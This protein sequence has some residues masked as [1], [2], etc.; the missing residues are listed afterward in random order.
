[1]LKVAI[2]INSDGLKLG[3]GIGSRAEF[4]DPGVGSDV[5]HGEKVPAADGE[6]FPVSSTFGRDRLEFDEGVGRGAELVDRGVDIAA[7]AVA[8][9]CHGEK[10]PPVDHEVFHASSTHGRDALELDK[11]VRRRAELVDRGVEVVDP[12][13]VAPVICHSKKVPV[14]DRK[15]LHS[16]EPPSYTKD[17]NSPKR[18]CAALNS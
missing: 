3:E 2:F 6:V 7:A 14:A 11:G 10:V 16:W 13:T 18:S 9:I 8:V 15:V 17:W 4:V 5:C 1:M 12:W